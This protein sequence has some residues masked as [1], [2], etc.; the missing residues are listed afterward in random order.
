MY[1]NLA[2]WRAFAPALAALFCNPTTL[3]AQ[4]P[5]A[6]VKAAFVY[7]APLTPTGWVRQHELGRQAVQVF[8]AVE[9]TAGE[10]G[11]LAEGILGHAR[12]L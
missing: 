8:L 5:T 4:A 10:A 1:K 11:R 2:A 7:V 9:L 6:P 3:H 12:H